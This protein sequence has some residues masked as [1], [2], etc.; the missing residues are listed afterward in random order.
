MNNMLD[1]DIEKKLQAIDKALTKLSPHEEE[2]HICP[3]ECG[4]NRRKE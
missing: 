3:R 4:V 2:C 1:I